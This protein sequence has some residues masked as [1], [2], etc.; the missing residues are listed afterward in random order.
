MVR[1]NLRTRQCGGPV[2]AALRGNL[3]AAGVL[4]SGAAL[5]AAVAGRPWVVADPAGPGFM[6]CAAMGAPAAAESRRGW[7]GATCCWLRRSSRCYGCS[8][9]PA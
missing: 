9:S 2:V 5:A 8:S 3:G 7:P 1:V 6:D 4:S